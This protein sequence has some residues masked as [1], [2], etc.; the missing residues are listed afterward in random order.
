MENMDNL[1]GATTF[2][3]LKLPEN[4][5]PFD[6]FDTEN[7]KADV[8]TWM[9][10]ANALGYASAQ[11]ET[12]L[13]EFP[14]IQNLVA[15]RF[16][17]DLSQI[18]TPAQI[19][20]LLHKEPEDFTS[21]LNLCKELCINIVTYDDET[22]PPLLKNIDSPPLVLYY[23]GD[24]NLLNECLTIAVIGT[25][26]PSAYG[27][28]ATRAITQGLAKEGAVLISGLAEGLDSECHKASLQNSAPTVAC[29]AFGHDLCYPACNKKLKEL[30]EKYGLVIGEYPPTTQIQK[31][32]FLQR[33]RLIAGLSYGLCV[34]EA[35]ERS[36]TL[37]TVSSALKYGRDVFS[38]P[39]SI[40]S[41]LCEGTN[42]LL[43]EGAVPVTTH[44]DIL[45]WY[46]YDIEEENKKKAVKSAKKNFSKE[47]KR[48]YDI[49]SV[50]PITLQEICDKTDMPV[51]NIM[52]ILTQLE[53]DGVVKQQAG[54]Q[55][56]LSDT[57]Y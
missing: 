36:G 1:S 52:V 48:V 17:M 46:G 43:K 23:R 47:T 29:I 8:L 3:R 49:L 7:E 18:F 40:F 26:R 22:Y 28:E 51:Q 44:I 9:W 30:I 50:K 32:F 57:F 14:N 41:P 27:I 19:S 10:L 35:R 56:V 21:R 31:P 12:V 6:Y 25:R 54:R 4:L 20:E 11:A 55:F 24:I 5:R 53:L 16:N 45:R 38:V 37:N 2:N 34:A 15:D 42:K 33:N 39:G 13:R